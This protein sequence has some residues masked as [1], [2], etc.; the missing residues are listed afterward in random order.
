MVP[1]GYPCTM[2]GPVLVAFKTGHIPLHPAPHLGAIQEVAHGQQRGQD[3]LEGVI[4][5]Q[6]LHAHLQIK[7]WLCNLLVEERDAGE[8][9]WPPSHLGASA[10]ALS[11]ED[12]HTLVNPSP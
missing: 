2:A 8:T 10:C 4:S 6:L 9:P 3:A 7:E 5:G 12:N 1:L 11:H